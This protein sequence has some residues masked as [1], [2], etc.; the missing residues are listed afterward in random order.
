MGDGNFI[1]PINGTIRKA[2]G[3]AMGDSVSVK[4]ELDGRAPTQ[5]AIFLKCLKDDPKAFDFFKTLPKSHQNYYS[6][7]IESAKTDGTKTKRITMAVMSLG[8]HQRFNEMMR[9]NRQER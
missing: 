2:T 3:K 7:W 1:L 6:K 9:A 5:S 4:L 8:Q